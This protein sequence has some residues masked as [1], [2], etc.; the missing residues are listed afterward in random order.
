MQQLALWPRWSVAKKM[1]CAHL[2][3]VDAGSMWR[4]STPPAN[5]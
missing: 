4:S 5:S 1:T 3:D 2:A